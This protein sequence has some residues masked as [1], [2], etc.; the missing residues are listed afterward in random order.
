MNAEI[1][2]LFPVT[3]NSVYLDNA[4]ISPTPTTTIQAGANYAQKRSLGEAGRTDDW[5]EIMEDCK[6]KFAQLTHTQPHQ[7]AII[8][9][10]SEGTNIVANMVNFQ[11][12]DNV[13]WDDLDHITNKLI[14]INLSKR[15]GIEN[16]ILSSE[17]NQIPVAAYEKAVDK[18]TKVISISLVAH[19]N[20][21]YYD[22]EKLADIAHLHGAYL[23]VDAIQTVGAL[24]MDLSKSGIDFL[25]CGTY[26]WLCGPQ[27]LGF[28]YIHESLLDL[29]QPIYSGWMQMKNWLD[30]TQISQIEL[31]KDARK[32]QT[33]TLDPRSMIE[34]SASLDLILQV[35]TN[36]IEEY[37]Q[38]LAVS[39]RTGLQEMGFDL[40]SPLP[41]RS[42]IVTCRTPECVSI[43]RYLQQNRCVITTR[44]DLLR[45]S[46]HFFNNLADIQQ[47][48]D[49]LESYQKAD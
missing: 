13:V 24:E 34:L 12:G 32:F 20:G 18:R 45:F 15:K 31:F 22:I 38:S 48:L 43:G 1:R 19:N 23:H 42:S 35:G 25:T 5:S 21:F 2:N 37:N 3:R 47:V 29:F 26:K 8:G 4:Y 9:N 27:G 7:I 14:W 6:R 28:F 10:T 33:A 41:V 16:R 30:D 40:I 46:P 11:P 49:L 39:L 17:L 44:K 36:A